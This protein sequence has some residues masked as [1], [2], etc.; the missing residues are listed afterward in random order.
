MMK[1]YA[2]ETI[3]DILL[4]LRKAQGQDMQDTDVITRYELSTGS[5]GVR[6][7]GATIWGTGIGSSF[8]LGN[9]INGLLGSYAS[10][11]LG[12]WRTGSSLL[13]SGAYW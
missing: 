7:S 9:P 13:Y 6:V 8:I 4:E 12:D 3:K 5:T 1:K 2:T 10:H 11:S